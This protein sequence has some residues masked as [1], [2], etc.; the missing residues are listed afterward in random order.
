MFVQ[1]LIA[2]VTVLVFYLWKTFKYWEYEG[3]PYEKPVSIPF[4]SLKSLMTRERSFGMAIYDV[5]NKTKEPFLGIYL[6]TRP[7]VLVRDP[8][9]C[10]DILTK[11]FA[12]FHDR[13]IY[14]DEENDPFSGNLFAAEGQ[15]WKSL[16]SKLTPSFTSGK[17]KSMYPTILETADKLTDSLRSQLKKGESKVIEIKDLM[18]SFAIDIIASVIFGIEI[19][20]FKNPDNEFR[21]VGRTNDKQNFFQNFMGAAFFLFPGIIHIISKLKLKDPNTEFMKRIVGETVEFREKNNVVRKDLMQMLIQLRNSGKI[22]EDDDNW[23]FQT[24]AEGLKSMSIE[25]LA[26][27]GFIFF[28]AGFET[29]SATAS[30]CLY[31]LT[32]NPELKD[33]LINEIDE[34]LAKHNGQLTYEGLK[35]MKLLDRCIMETNR[36]Y[37]GLPILNRICTQ[38]YKVPGNSYT[39]KKG[40]PIII[41][42]MGLHRD[43]EHFPDPMKFDPDRFEDSNYN[44][45]AYMPFGEGPRNCIAFRM[46]RVSAMTAIVS[47]LSNFNIECTEK[48]ELE[49]DNF[50]VAIIPK[51]GVNV[52]FTRK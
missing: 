47:V 22:N 23:K 11:D 37:P 45:T 42:L 4:G 20:S 26:G 21:S 27:Q 18:N 51:G 16:R 44:S 32:Q 24:V 25:K 14:V 41:S 8:N 30:Y 48:R 9:L 13:G 17:L 36:K 46:G 35:E 33:R 28:I 7:A 12:S 38:D 39:I 34:V 50:S 2:A 31:E 40:T 43:P 19:D 49:I 15:S 5:Y 3:I 52:K 1:L 29:T 10:K 6:M